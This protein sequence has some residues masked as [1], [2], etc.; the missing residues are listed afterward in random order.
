ML[1]RALFENG[2]GRTVGYGSGAVG[3]EIGQD[4]LKVGSEGSLGVRRWRGLSYDKVAGHE[5]G[6]IILGAMVIDGAAELVL[7]LT[8]AAAGQ[9][10]Q[11]SQ[12]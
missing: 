10:Q 12:V 7:I 8:T 6:T 2:V 1:V 11:I 9:L 4:L 3:A 5:V